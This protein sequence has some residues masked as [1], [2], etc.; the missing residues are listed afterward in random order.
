MAGPVKDSE[1]V[2]AMVMVGFAIILLTGVVLRRLA[3]RFRQPGV[4]GELF[5]GLVLGPSLL[6]LLPGNLTEVLFPADV[7]PYLSVLAQVGVV[8]F[9][10]L[11][12]WEFDSRLLRGRGRM[13]VG[14]SLSAMLL[15]FLL[16]LPL[17]LLL[18][19]GHSVVNGEQVGQVPF[20][21]YTGVVISITAFPV[22]ARFLTDRRMQNTQVGVMA[23]AC[24]AFG[25]AI[26]WCT[27]A[28]VVVIVTAGSLLGVAAMAGWLALFLAVMILVVRPLL[29][30]LVDRMS[31]GTGAPYLVAVVGAGVFL[32]SCAT[33]WIG[34]HAIFGAFVFGMVMPRPI[35][36]Q[37]QKYALEPV[38]QISNFLLPL[39]FI[40]VGMSI[41]LTAL[42]L[43]NSMELVLILAVACAGKLIGAAV[44][45]RLLGM[46]WQQSRT[47]GLLMNMRGLTELIV[48]NVGLGLGL[49]SQEVYSMM[50]VMALFTTCLPG[51]FLRRDADPTLMEPVPVPPAASSATAPATPPAAASASVPQKV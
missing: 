6:G 19:R 4:I 23:L 3:A 13:V 9:V 26:A 25:D 24:A 11:I 31:L 20:T 48:L 10:F 7:R 49:L 32:A 18:Y 14:V 34:V 16:G 45:A 39:F 8:L 44:P 35:H 29:A 33:T 42:S 22:L 50:V 30:R 40:V 5:A 36:P 17:A 21:L 27:L 51:L 1:S 47:L 41:D 12:G 43:G 46:S 38:E 28:L 37:L 2:T 15:P